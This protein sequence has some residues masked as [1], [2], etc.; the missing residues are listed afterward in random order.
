MKD[1]PQLDAFLNALWLE[2]G[3][4]EHTRQAY[5][6]DIKQAASWLQQKNKTLLNC[7]QADIQAFLAARLQAGISS[8]SI[9]RMLSSLR[10]YFQ[11]L[12]RYQHRNTDPT[13][14]IA[15]PILPKPLPHTLNEQ[16]VTALLKAPDLN[17]AIG[18][19][20]RTMLELLYACGLRISELITLELNQINLKQGVIRI[21]GKG[22][23]E[24][25]VPMGEHAMSW[26]QRYINEARE[27]FAGK[28]HDCL[29]PG[30]GGNVLTRQA[31]W[32]RIKHYAR[33]ANI[34][35]HLSPHTLRH[36]FATHLLNHGADLRVVQML[37]GHSSLSTTQIY[38]H[39]AKERLKQL[40]QEHHPRG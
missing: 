33:Q 14:D 34:K 35:S 31:F 16:E 15:S 28:Q 6:R 17:T 25:L 38:T 37:L 20:D 23:K 10:K 5:L 8:R 27:K 39:I 36:A 13:Q 3:R 22:Q 21:L 1:T 24:R 4:S 30:R 11:Y 18:L 26:L 40:H 7:K 9:A 29:F 19:R 2:E 12:L 32:Y